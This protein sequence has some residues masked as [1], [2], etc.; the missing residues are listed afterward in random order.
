MFYQFMEV[1]QNFLYNGN[2]ADT[3]YEYWLAVVLSGICCI[4]LLYIP[5]AVVRW[6]FRGF[7]K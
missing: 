3:S 6:F 1:I 4:M 5:F 2:V 7:I